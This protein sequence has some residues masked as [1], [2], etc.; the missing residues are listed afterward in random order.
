MVSWIGIAVSLGAAAVCVAKERE[1]D[2]LTSLLLTD[3][4]AEEILRQKLVGVLGQTR[5][6]YY[7]QLIVGIPAILCGAYEWWA[8]LV[9]FLTQAIYSVCAAT[10]GLVV[11]ATAAT[12]EK[13]S[14][15][16]AFIVAGALTIAAFGT[17]PVIALLATPG[18]AGSHV[19]LFALAAMFPPAVLLGAGQVHSMPPGAVPFALIGVVA[20][21]VIFLF[22]A[23]LFWRWARRRFLRACYGDYPEV[24]AGGVAK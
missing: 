11:T 5:G 13:A 14:R 8:F 18:V 15:S 6:V 23:W 20:G 9:L 4:S 22:L 7:W 19:E 3:L 10:L 21:W 1:R 12:A 2:T 16:I 17:G 24:A